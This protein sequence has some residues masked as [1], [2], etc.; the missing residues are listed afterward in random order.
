MTNLTT[1]VLDTSRGKP[2]EGMKIILFKLI[3]N[4]LEKIIEVTTNKDGRIDE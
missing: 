4:N 2:A 3:D 1:H